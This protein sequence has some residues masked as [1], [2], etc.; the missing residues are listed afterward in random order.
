MLDSRRP[1]NHSN[2]RGAEGMA[3]QQPQPQNIKAIG[4]HAGTT[5]AMPDNRLLL[6]LDD[7]RSFVIDAE[8][9]KAQADGSYRVDFTVADYR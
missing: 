5:Q 4:S 6:T 1:G 3:T 2:F 7:G 9:L 8:R